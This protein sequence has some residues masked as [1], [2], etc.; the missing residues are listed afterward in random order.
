MNRAKVVTTS[1]FRL[2]MKEN[3]EFPEIDWGRAIGMMEEIGGSKRRE[4]LIALRLPRG[5]GN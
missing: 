2:R 4:H 1:I 5:E 3:E